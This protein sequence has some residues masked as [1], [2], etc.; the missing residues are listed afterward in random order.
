MSIDDTRDSVIAHRVIF[1][2]DDMV[3]RHLALTDRRMRQQGEACDVSSSVDSRVRR[4][5]VGI[6]DDCRAVRSDGEGLEA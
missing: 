5:H 6:H 2:T 4:L 1:P 3:D